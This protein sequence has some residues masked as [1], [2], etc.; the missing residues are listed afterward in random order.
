MTFTQ[1]LLRN[2]KQ[3]LSFKQGKQEIIN[4]AKANHTEIP[5]YF[6]SVLNI[7]NEDKPSEIEDASMTRQDLPRHDEQRT[8]TNRHTTRTNP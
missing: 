4:Y 2:G 5:N 8:H 3:R 1:Y 6:E 7:F